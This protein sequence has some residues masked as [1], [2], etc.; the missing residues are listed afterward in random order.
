MDLDDLEKIDVR[1]QA[2]SDHISVNDLGG[3]SVVTVNVD[4]TSAGGATDADIVTVGGSA[5]D[6]VVT[7]AGDAYGVAVSGLA[8]GVNISGAEAA[9]D[10]LVILAGDGA[11][12]IDA[13]VLSANGVHLTA[14]GGKGDDVLLGGAGNDL[15]LGGDGDD[16]L[17]GG[18][19]DDVLDGGAGEDILI[20]GAGNDILLNGEY[21]SADF[22]AGED[23]VD[24]RSLSELTFDWVME[25]A[26]MVDGN[27]V[28][29]LGNGEHITLAGVAVD[30]LHRDDFLFGP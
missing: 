21:T 27:A 9:Y 28:L 17:L 23:K 8:A 11:D 22:T 13:S 25:H 5:Y 30:T 10:R 14:D 18:D 15:L 26:T 3:T 19:G 20:G 29:D 16:V 12:V 6:D 4:L 7:V 2:G 24:L 1:A